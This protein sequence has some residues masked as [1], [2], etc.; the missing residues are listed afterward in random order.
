MRLMGRIAIAVAVAWLL[1]FGV[2]LVCVCADRLAESLF[3]SQPL[4]LVKA[5]HPLC[6][7]IHDPPLL[8]TPKG[9]LDF[10]PGKPTNDH[11][12]V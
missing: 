2:A 9:R 10:T 4:P 7:T 11:G 12:V 5:D 3:P 6:V 1:L 8:R